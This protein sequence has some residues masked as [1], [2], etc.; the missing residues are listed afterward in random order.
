MATH[1]SYA[2]RPGQA[3]SIIDL[4]QPAQPTWDEPSAAE[5][6]A[7]LGYL[8]GSTAAEG[9]SE[10]QR[11][12]V[13]G[14]CIDGNT[15][16]ALMAISKAWWLRQGQSAMSCWSR[17]KVGVS[18][19]AMSGLINQY[20]SFSVALPLGP[21]K[22]RLTTEFGEGQPPTSSVVRSSFAGYLMVLLRWCHRR[23]NVR[24]G[25]PG[26]VVTDGGGE[27]MEVAITD[28]L[29]RKEKIAEMTPMALQN[30]AVAQHR[31]QL[32]NA[33][34]SQTSTQMQA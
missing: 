8:P 25:A 28:L 17:L 19:L 11:R 29:V 18:K 14:Q 16:Q 13:L 1:G 27:F 7:A 15:A 33:Q 5:R 32:R 6:E 22:A 12:R 34:R 31:D 20:Y 23:L 21:S 30:L 2:F 4:S 24:F 9:V 3:G 26:Q 10:L